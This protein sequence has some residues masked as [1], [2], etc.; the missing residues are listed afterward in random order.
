MSK[1]V[2]KTKGKPVEKFQVY[3][4]YEESESGGEVCEGDE[5]RAFPDHEDLYREFT[6]KS[7][8]LEPGN[9]S[10]A[11]EVNFDPAKHSHL[12]VVIVRYQSGDTFGVSHGNWQVIGACQKLKEA[13][14]VARSIETGSY[15][16]G[17]GKRKEWEGYFESLETV[18]IE[19][20]D[21]WS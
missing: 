9:W 7:L 11:I 21:V 5:D 2:R 13:K 10:E 12:Y 19:R 1:T 20:I 18:D 15:R 14:K 3:L 6:A 17:R 4:F 8:Q 16:R